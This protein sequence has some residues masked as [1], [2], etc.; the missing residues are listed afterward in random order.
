LTE[1]NNDGNVLVV[2]P[3]VDN[4]ALTNRCVK[5]ILPTLGAG[6][7]LMLFSNGSKPGNLARIKGLYSGSDKVDIRLRQ[8]NDDGGMSIANVYNFGLGKAF[9]GEGQTGDYD[10]IVL[11]HNDCVVKYP[12]WLTEMKLAIENNAPTPTLVMTRSGTGSCSWEQ[13]MKTPMAEPFIVLDG[14]A[15]KGYCMMLD[16]HTF[17]AI[18]YFDTQFGT[19]PDK[20]YMLRLFRN[21]PAGVVVVCRDVRVDHAGNKTFSRTM[22]RSQ[23][24]DAYHA[25]LRR[26]ADKYK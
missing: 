1:S 17:D 21:R 18:G 15:V 12:L 10:Y 2:V 9:V 7:T 19:M 13:D 6:D 24:T 20:D 5:S 11:M 22:T 4:A 3:F 25:D 16:K 8:N 14:T 26:L 23:F